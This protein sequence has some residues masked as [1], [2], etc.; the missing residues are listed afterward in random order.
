VTLGF[1]DSFLLTWRNNAGQDRV[2]SS[3]LPSE[4][5]EFVYARDRNIANIRC[6]LGP[7]NASFFVHDNA[8]YLWNNLPD[9]LLSSLQGIIQDGNWTDRPRLVALGASN[10]F[11][12]VTEKNAARWDV[13]NY[14]ELSKLLKQGHVSAI[15][16]VLLHPYR[17]QSFVA[18][19]KSGDLAYENMPQHQLAGI[20]AMVEPILRDTKDVR[21]KLLFRRESEVRDTLQRRPSNLQQRAQLRREWSEHRQEIT[22]QAKGVKLGLS[23]NISLGGLARM[24]G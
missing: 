18:Q 5:N 10:N 11:L 8:S 15:H 22:A 17:V 24:L 20:Q 2:E 19:H 1:E 13:R 16:S 9:Q 4:L 23:L 14:N 12:L 21:P 7:Y 6:T 3:G